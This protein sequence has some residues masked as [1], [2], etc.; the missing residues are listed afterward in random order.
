MKIEANGKYLGIDYLN[1]R[2][3]WKGTEKCDLSN[4]KKVL[5]SLGEPQDVVPSVIVGGTNGKGSVSSTIASILGSQSLRVGLNIS[6]HLFS[7]TERVIIDG[8]SISYESLDRALIKVS[9]ASNSNAI[10]LSF[11]EVITV[12]AFIIFANSVIDLSVIE[13]GVGGRLDAA[14]TVSSPKV[15][16]IV[17]I[18]LDHEQILGSTLVEIA[19]EKAGII[20]TAAP[21]VIG[22]LPQE[23]L[24][25]IEDRARH[26]GANVYA[27]GR[28]FLLQTD[29]DSSRVVLSTEKVISLN[30]SLQGEHQLE[31]MA[32]AAQVGALLECSLDSISK[33]IKQV[34]WP[35]RI[36][37]IIGR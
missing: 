5:T 30:P 22:R 18:D 33:G 27:L 32:V 7:V 3:M 11:H 20:K 6:P 34:Y 16:S 12:A 23:A 2:S 36:E 28:D 1:K 9:Q 4:I 29:G 24:T 14:N 35:A 25:V 10:D 21:V 31:N 8:R 15:V 17:S 37:S 26:F 13:V 19:K